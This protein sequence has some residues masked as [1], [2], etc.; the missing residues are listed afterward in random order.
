MQE[1]HWALQT[2]EPT[3]PPAVVVKVEIT[4]GDQTREVEGT[5]DTGADMTELQPPY[6][7]EFGVD[8]DT[9][10]FT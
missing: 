8:E 6:F 7:D 5:F 10:G 2:N 4:I 9:V 3:D 1:I